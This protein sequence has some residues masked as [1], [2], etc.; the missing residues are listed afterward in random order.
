[1]KGNSQEKKSK[2]TFSVRMERSMFDDLSRMAEYQ[3]R[4]KSSLVRYLIYVAT[5][6][7][8]EVSQ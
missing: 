1:M 7:F 5:K 2:V 8:T 3:K 6:T 4:T